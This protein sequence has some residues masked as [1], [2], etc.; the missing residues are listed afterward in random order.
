[1]R[2]RYF[3]P[4]RFLTG[5][6]IVDGMPVTDFDTGDGMNTN[7]GVAVIGGMV[8]GTFQQDGIAVLIAQAQINS[9]WC[10]HVTQHLVAM[11]SEV[12]LLHN[13]LL[14]QKKTRQSLAGVGY[15]FTFNTMALP[16]PE[17]IAVPPCIGMFSAV[18]AAKMWF[19]ARFSKFFLCAGLSTFEEKIC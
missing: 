7:E 19:P 10:I 15:I 11:G 6:F 12:D 4:Y 1:M 16:S 9:N 3:F 18:H 2:I 13:P 14:W 17:E 5:Q 8:I